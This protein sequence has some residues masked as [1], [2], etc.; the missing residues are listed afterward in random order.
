MEAVL[1]AA[2]LV[3]GHV[4]DQFTELRIGEQDG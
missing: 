1:K 3:S 2:R 4:A